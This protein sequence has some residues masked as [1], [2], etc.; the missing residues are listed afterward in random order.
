MGVANWQ[1]T[2]VAP[3]FFPQAIPH[4]LQQRRKN[5]GVAQPQEDWKRVAPSDNN[6]PDT[7]H[8]KR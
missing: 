1:N 5:V 7:S 8:L 3:L 2:R 4:L 6:P